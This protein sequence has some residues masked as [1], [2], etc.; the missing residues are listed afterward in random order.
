MKSKDQVLLEGIYT[1]V[2]N[3]SNGG[4]MD[5]PDSLGWWWFYGDITYGAI[6]NEPAKKDLHCVPIVYKEGSTF[7]SPYKGMMWYIS[8]YDP[9]HS[10]RLSGREGYLG[11][12]KKCEEPDLPAWPF[13]EQNS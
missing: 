5:A 7:V 13:E 4:W 11:L 10:K 12:W 8:P 3:E 9:K 1:N 6:L 2:L